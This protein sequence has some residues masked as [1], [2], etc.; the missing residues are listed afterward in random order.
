MQ[1]STFPDT[2]PDTWYHE[3]LPGFTPVFVKGY[4]HYAYGVWASRDAK[5][6]GDLPI[7]LESHDSQLRT[8]HQEIVTRI[9]PQGRNCMEHVSGLLV[10]MEQLD[11]FLK[12]D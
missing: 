8:D 4:W 9:D 1:F 5:A 6:G 12:H 2:A 3:L 10:P 11:D 7:C